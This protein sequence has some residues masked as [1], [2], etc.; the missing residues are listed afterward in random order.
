MVGGVV[1]LVCAGDAL[2]DLA[3]ALESY[4]AVEG[5]PDWLI[6]AVWLRSAG[7]EYLATT[8]T[9]VLSDGFIARPLVIERTEEFVAKLK[10]ELPDISARLQ[11]RQSRIE[12]PGAERPSSPE[13][14]REWQKGPYSTS[15]LIR[16]AASGVM[17]HHVS[18]GL[19]L[20]QEGERLLI[21]TD[22]ATPSMVLSRDSDL[23]DRY[24]SACTC[25][26]AQDYLSAYD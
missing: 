11:A 18:C 17:I 14:A 8:S 7:G 3:S 10:C 25:V 12:L 22:P 23:I 9:K 2:G 13:A 6:S 26:S 4:G 15:V 24:A 1:K 20:E 21:G 19:L 16:P 5:E